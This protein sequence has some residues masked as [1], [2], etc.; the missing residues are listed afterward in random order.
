MALSAL[1]MRAFGRLFVANKKPH[2]E[3]TESRHY[4]SSPQL[5]WIN[6]LDRTVCLRDYSELGKIEALNAENV[7]IKK[8]SIKPT[9]Y[10][11]GHSM[12]QKQYSGH[13]MI[14]LASSELPLYERQM[15]PNPSHYLT[16]GCSFAYMSYR[17]EKTDY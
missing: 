9:R 5:E 7:V 10:Y 6:M 15:V 3:K 8:G 16:L 12:L 13:Y 2:E 4:C 1:I 14:D 11:V 17:N